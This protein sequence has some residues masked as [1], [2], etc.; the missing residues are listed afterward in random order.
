MK[1]PH[2]IK[3][4]EAFMD[5]LSLLVYEVSGHKLIVIQILM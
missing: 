3:Q 4:Y 5:D 1:C 2:S